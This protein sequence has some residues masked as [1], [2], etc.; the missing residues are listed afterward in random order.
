MDHAAAGRAPITVLITRRIV[1]ARY[2]DFKEWQK[3]GLIL[4]A[5]FPGF[6]GSGVLEAPEGDDRVQTI[7]RFA[8]GVRFRHFAESVARR[9]WLERGAEMVIETCSQQSSGLDAWFIQAAGA[10]PWWRRAM[11]LSLFLCSLIWTLAVLVGQGMPGWPTLP[12]GT[13]AALALAPAGA[14]LCAP[15]AMRAWRVA[16]TPLRKPTIQWH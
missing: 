1:A 10:A 15:F 9:M 13:L 6:L 5:G 2:G 7:L 12:W 3:E 4:A 8:D 16:T 11:P 14:L